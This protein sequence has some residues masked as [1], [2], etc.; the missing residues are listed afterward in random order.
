MYHAVADTFIAVAVPCAA[1]VLEP[2]VPVPTK[3]MMSVVIAIVTETALGP[4]TN[5]IAVPMG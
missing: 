3:Y 2:V 5:V 1:S 4:A